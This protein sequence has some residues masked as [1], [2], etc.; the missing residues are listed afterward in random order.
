MLFP[1]VGVNLQLCLCGVPMYASAQT[2][3]FLA[4]RKNPRFP[5]RKPTV[6]RPELMGVNSLVSAMAETA[7]KVVIDHSGCLHEGITDGCPDKAEADALQLPA[8]GI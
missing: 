8:H 1:P 6:S 7:G 4:R 2:L 3:D 5:E